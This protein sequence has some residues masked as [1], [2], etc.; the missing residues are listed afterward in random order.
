[1]GR[2]AGEADILAQVADEPVLLGLEISGDGVHW[3][4]GCRRDTAA[5]GATRPVRPEL[6]TLLA[7]LG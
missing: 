7:R 6:Q 3:G 5:T 2:Y 1:L 4:A